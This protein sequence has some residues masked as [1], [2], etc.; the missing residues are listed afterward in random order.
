MVKV[1]IIIPTRNHE[2]TIQ[3]CLNSALSQKTNFDYEIIV[4][5]DSSEDNT[6]NIL[7][8]IASRHSNVIIVER[9]QNL[10][11]T[12]NVYDLCLRMRGDYF[13]YL[14][15]DDYW[16]DENKL[17][18]QYDFLQANPEYVGCFHDVKLIASDGTPLTKKLDWISNKKIVTLKNFDGYRLPG[19]SSTWLRKNLY[20]SSPE[21]FELVYTLNRDIGDRSAALCFLAKGA[22][23]NVGGEMSCYRFVREKKANNVTSLYYLRSNNIIAFELDILNKMETYCKDVLKV[24]KKFETRRHELS[25]K[26]FFRAVKHPTK[27]NKENLSKAFGSC[28]NKLLFVLK[29]PLFTMKKLWKK[30]NILYKN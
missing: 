29:L 30:I 15:G 13:A 23:Y 27:E 1:S 9:Q 22:F 14:E 24:N 26:A 6:L 11:A 5:D 20:K 18:K 3:Q 8:E 16:C 12:K 28:T 10:G 21:D 19:H 2:H 7:K 25:A 17:Q 4:G